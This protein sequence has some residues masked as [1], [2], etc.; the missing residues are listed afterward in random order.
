MR[1]VEV[2]RLSFNKLPL[3]RDEQRQDLLQKLPVHTEMILHISVAMGY[4]TD[5]LIKKINKINK[6]FLLLLQDSITH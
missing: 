2:L 4:L 3:V 1:L 5:W 6:H